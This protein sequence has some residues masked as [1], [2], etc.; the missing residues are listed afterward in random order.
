MKYFITVT[1]LAIVSQSISVDAG[2]PSAAAKKALEEARGCNVSNWGIDTVYDD[3]QPHSV[4]SADDCQDIE[5]NYHDVA[6][7]LPPSTPTPSAMFDVIKQFIDTIDATGGVRIVD[8]G[9]APVADEDWID[10]GDAYMTACRAIDHTPKI[11][12]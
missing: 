7:S 6:E 2:S 3:R 1:R 9:T 8:D 4:L 11:V 10:L 12:S 5:G